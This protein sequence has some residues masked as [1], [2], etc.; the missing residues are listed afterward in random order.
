MPGMG[1]KKPGGKEMGWRIKGGF[2][3]FWILGVSLIVTLC[4]FEF[5]S[6]FLPRIKKKTAIYSS[7]RSPKSFFSP[8]ISQLPDKHFSQPKRSGGAQKNVPHPRNRCER[9]KAK[10]KF[11]DKAKTQVSICPLLSNLEKTTFGLEYIQPR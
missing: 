10:K 1:K 9:K 11:V 2:F 4:F 8:S 7:I 6:L 5:Q 3:F